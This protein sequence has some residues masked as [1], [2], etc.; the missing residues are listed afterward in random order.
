M[1][2]LQLLD[3]ASST[4]TYLLHDPATREAVLIDPVDTQ[5]ERDLAVLQAH[6]LVLRWTLETHAHADHITSAGLLA[7]HTGARTAV[8]ADC[9][10]GTAAVQ[11][12]PGD[13]SLLLVDLGQGRKRMGGGLLAQVLGR[14]GNEVPDLDDAQA[15]KSLV[16]AVNALRAQGRILAY[17][18][19][20][21][22][23]LWAAVC[24]M[25]FAG[26]QGVSLNVD[27]LVTEGDGIADSAFRP[28][29]LMDHILWSQPA[30]ALLTGSP[31]VQLIRWAQSSFPAT[32]PGGVVDSHPLMQA[33]R[34]AVPE[35]VAQMEAAANP[36]WLQAG[37]D[38]PEIDPLTSH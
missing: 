35:A 37:F 13:T 33:P 15:L 6:G 12:Q 25:A 28:N 5:L 29:D 10:I 32:L 30:A 19:R 14:F 31:A 9:G 7:E 2:P 1:I 24:E 3:P 18:D 26:R 36:P 22:G 4:Y 27:I 34:I 11:L 38:D 23:G 17:H 16:T 20:S 8:P 21:D